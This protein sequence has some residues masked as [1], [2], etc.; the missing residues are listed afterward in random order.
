M[1]SFNERWYHKILVCIH[2]RIFI[3]LSNQNSILL[4]QH[5]CSFSF[6]LFSL[7]ILSILFATP[8]FNCSFFFK[9]YKLYKEK[10]SKSSSGALK[11]F[12]YFILSAISLGRVMV[13][14]P[15]I[16]INHPRI[17]RIFI[18]R[19]THT[20]AFKFFFWGGVKFF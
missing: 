19:Q 8:T 1:S 3:R 6:S 12:G 14:T 11:Y 10:S 7:D 9:F 5:N 18:S 16:T 4:Q 2:F 17:I 20:G 15:Q 13:P